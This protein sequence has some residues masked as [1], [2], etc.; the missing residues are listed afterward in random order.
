MALYPFLSQ[1]YFSREVFLH[2][3]IQAA[4]CGKQVQLNHKARI[5]HYSA[6]LYLIRDDPTDN[7]AKDGGPSS[8]SFYH[9]PLRSL[10]VK[11]VQ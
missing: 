11:E 1:S 8:R 5:E 4:P 2:Y 7:Y 3:A 10:I 6:T 9:E